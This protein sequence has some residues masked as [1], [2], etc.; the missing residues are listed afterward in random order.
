MLSSSKQPSRKLTLAQLTH[1][2]TPS[3]QRRHGDAAV[4][5]P[6]RRE[7]T[8]GQRR[9]SR[10]ALSTFSEAAQEGDAPRHVCSEATAGNLLTWTASPS[11]SG[12]R[13]IGARPVDDD[14][15]PRHGQRSDAPTGERNP[16][17]RALRSCTTR[18]EP[19][20]G[21]ERLRQGLG[22]GVSAVAM[23]PDGGCRPSR[24]HAALSSFG[25]RFL[26]FPRRRRSSRPRRPRRKRVRGWGEGG[27]G[28]GP[29]RT[30]LRRSAP[31]DAAAFQTGLAP[32]EEEGTIRRAL[33]FSFHSELLTPSFFRRMERKNE[34]VRTHMLNLRSL[35]YL[36]RLP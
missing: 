35:S 36:V 5:T 1:G 23:E 24:T 33:P 32:E 26:G 21:R 16:H 13:G 2:V 17:G 7:T 18:L 8:S 15:V 28:G 27:K 19:R 20:C 25:S 9:P 34:R 6:L 12:D 30:A 14:Q 4:V 10:A 29:D 3:D 11:A 22:G 31:S